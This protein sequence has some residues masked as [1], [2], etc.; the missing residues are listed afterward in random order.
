MDDGNG[1][2]SIRFKV[3]GGFR[4]LIISIAFLVDVSIRFKVRGDFRHREKNVH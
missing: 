3:R 2:V 1:I 4:L